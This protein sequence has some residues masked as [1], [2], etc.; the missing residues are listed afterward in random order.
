MSDQKVSELTST[1]SVSNTDLFMVIQSGSNK[2]ISIA[3]LFANI[4]D[5]VIVNSAGSGSIS[6]VVKGDTDSNLLVSAPASDRVGVG[7]A[8]PAE[9]LD[10]NGNLLVSGGFLRLSQSETL[11]CTGASATADVTKA[12]TKIK[13]NT[14]TCTISLAD[15]VEGQLKEFAMTDKGTNN[16]AVAPTNCVGFTSVTFSANGQTCEFKFLSGKWYLKSVYG[17][18]VA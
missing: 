11:N 14:T 17:A 15:G 5:N 7:V 10:V 16:A 1:S 8:S 9:K 3:N 18:T 13:T 6:F 2:K 4:Q 12:I